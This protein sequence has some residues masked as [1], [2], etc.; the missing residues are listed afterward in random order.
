MF[1]SKI[2]GLGYYVPENIVTNDDLS[3]IMDTNDAWIQ[4]RTGIQE[5]RHIIKGEDTT[6]TMG[7]K[8][9]KIAIERSGIPKD[10]IDFIIFATLSPDYYFPGPGVLVQ[11][12]LGLKTVGALDVRNQCSGFV[13]AISI[14]DQYIKT[15]MYRNILVIGSEVHSA[16]LDFTDRGRGV[17]V[18]FG[19]GAGAVVLSASE[20]ANAKG[21]LSVNMHSEGK[22]AEELAVKFPGTK[23]GW[24]DTLL[25]NPDSITS[26]DIYPVMNGNF[27]FKHAVTRFPETILEALEKAGKKIEDLD[28]L[29]PH[30]ANIRIAQYVQQLLHLPDEK[31]FVNIQKYGNTTAAS[32][33]IALSEAIQEG[34]MKRGD[35]VC[36]S[37]FGSGFTWG[38]VLF[39]Y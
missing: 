19:D 5:R 32:I 30:Q 21:I 34:R 3:K 23:L 24:S 31:V 10:D 26:E 18:I 33:P 14:A 29:I 35:L 27:V 6:T 8:A 39:E 13:Y 16:G 4:E 11:R 36:M 22:Y 2:T 1:H 28:L 15:G 7:V 37:A 38:S 12:D 25:T 9:A 17:S 20:D